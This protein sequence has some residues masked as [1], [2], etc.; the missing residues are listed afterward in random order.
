[1]W[2]YAENRFVNT[3]EQ[4]CGLL[5]GDHSKSG[6]NTMFNTGTVVGV[7]CNI[8]GA[9]F[10]RNFIPSFSWGGTQGFKLYNLKRAF[11]VAEAV[12]KRRNRQLDEA[13]RDMLTYL[14]EHSVIRA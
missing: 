1:V 11:N 4:F 3:G 12:M 7:F 6:I 5:M 2:S 8:Y 13:D 14:H 9:G 10:Q